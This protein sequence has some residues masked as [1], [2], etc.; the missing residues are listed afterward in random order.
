MPADTCH[1]V[2]LLSLT[3]TLA[4]FLPV[5]RSFFQSICVLGYCIFPLTLSA[6]VCLAVG[7][8]H[9][10]STLC[11]IIRLIAVA[12]GL[13]WSTRG[14]F[15]CPSKTLFPLSSLTCHSMHSRRGARYSA[16]ATMARYSAM[17]HA[18]SWRMSARYSAL[19]RKA[20]P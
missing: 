8:S 7:W 10:R 3:L 12:V 17:C 14:L 11:L 4:C 5:H 1:G 15:P 13:L 20:A 19:V 16:L 6:I 18:V 2:W 9:C